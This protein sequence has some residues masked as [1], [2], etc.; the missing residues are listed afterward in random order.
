MAENE[1]EA[2]IENGLR[3]LQAQINALQVAAQRNLRSQTHPSA[4]S[5][6]KSQLGDLLGTTNQVN[7]NN[8]DKCVVKKDN[9]T[10]SLPQNIHTGATPTF[11]GLKLLLDT[12]KVIFG[13]GSDM[14]IWYDGSK[15]Q[16]KTS[17]VAASDLQ[18][19]CGTEKTIELVNVVW[20]ELP[21]SP[22]L[23]ARL[24][25]TAPTLTAFVGGTEQY[26]FDAVNDYVIGATEVTHNYKEGTDIS[27][28]IHWATNGVDAG[29]TG[30]KWQLEYTIAN[31]DNAAPFASAFGATTTISID[32][33]I[34]GGT[35]DRSH[36]KSPFSADISGAGIKIGAYICWKLSRI[37]SATAAPA[38][39]PFALAIGFHIQVDTMG[40]RT[41]NTK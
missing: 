15:G 13:T 16:I 26:T 8:G 24:G 20:E 31:M 3:N 21:P 30:V 38:A 40:S 9:V 2:K 34:P 23:G 1:W 35:T 25:A 10:L 11:A 14:S 18:V 7:V 41:E 17:D 33:L 27:P 22:I 5:I 29:D 32:T 36:I 6:L 37:A 4:L 19:T 12:A 28:H 39:N